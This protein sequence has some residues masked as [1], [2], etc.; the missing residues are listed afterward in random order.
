[1][2]NWSEVLEEIKKVEFEI[3]SQS[4]SMAAQSAPD[5]V[6][7]NYL[8]TLFRKTGRN[9]IAYYSGWLSK[10]NIEGAQIN[11]EDKNGIMMAVHELDRSVGLDLILHT[12]GGELPATESII[13]Y[14]HRMFGDNIR[15]IV[16]QIAM[17]AGTLIACAGKEIVMGSHSNLGPIDPQVL[18]VPAYGVIEE[19]RVAAEEIKSDPS[20]VH[21]WHP[22]LSK[23][24]PTFLSQ[25]Q[26]AIEHSKKVA[27]R[28]LQKNML[29]RMKSKQ[30]RAEKIV[31][32]LTDY[33]KNGSHSRHIHIDECKA[34]GLKVKNL[35]SNPDLQDIVL[36]VHHAFI[37]TLMNTPAY[38]IV[39]NHLGRALVKMQVINQTR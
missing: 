21:V 36:T 27:L 32:G 6:R 7:R 17:S 29:K 12:P 30:S 22:I 39:E 15:V 5:L 23:Y 28:H 35:E 4:A 18:G 34:L 25:C 33:S 20:K 8:N 31:H 3:N 16:P 13:D 38:K 26:N 11:D 9:V 1:M 37:N 2:P 24:H 10:P 14:L 19:F